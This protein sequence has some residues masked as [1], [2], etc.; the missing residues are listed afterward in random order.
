M[1]TFTEALPALQAQGYTNIMDA[2]AA[3]NQQQQQSY[4]QPIA[5][6]VL[7][8]TPPLVVPSPAAYQAPP[9]PSPA[10]A[11][12]PA[13]TPAATPAAASSSYLGKSIPQDV[14]ANLKSQAFTVVPAKYELLD[15]VTPQLVPA[16]YAPSSNV[17]SVNDS[18]VQYATLPNGTPV[19]L[20]YNPQGNL[21]DVRPSTGADIGGNL[22]ATWGPSGEWSPLQK[23][24]NSFLSAVLQVAPI[25]ISLV[26]PELIP[27]LGQSILGTATLGTAEAIAG[28]AAVSAATTAIA[29]GNI[30][31]IA[32]SAAKTAISVGIGGNVAQ[33]V[34][35]T[36]AQSGVPTNVAKVVASSVGATA[37]AISTGGD[38]ARAAASGLIGSVG[39]QT[40]DNIRT[41]EVTDLIQ[42]P[43]VQLAKADTGTMTD[44]SAP[45]T[46]AI[47]PISGEPI[48]SLEPVVVTAGSA[49]DK[50]F[51]DAIK[52]IRVLFSFGSGTPEQTQDAVYKAI[53]GFPGGVAGG[54]P[55]VD[56]G[57]RLFAW[58]NPDQKQ[59]AIRFMQIILEDPQ[60]SQENKI[61]AQQSI[62]RINSIPT[63]QEVPPSEQIPSVSQLAA[64]SE[65]KVTAGGPGGGGGGG[66]TPVTGTP[67]YGVSGTQSFIDRIKG[68]TAPS[69]LTSD[70]SKWTVP[71]GDGTR[72]TDIKTPG[73]G[74][75]SDVVGPVGPPVPGATTD[76]ISGAGGGYGGGY[77]TGAGPGRGPGV[78]PGEGPGESGTGGYTTGIT[79]GPG[80]PG[81]GEPTDVVQPDDKYPVEKVPLPPPPRV[82][83]LFT[84][85]L[86]DLA[87]LAPIERRKKT[88]FTEDE[89][90]PVGRWGSETLR[91]LLGI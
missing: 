80:G 25:V 38:P 7:T 4:F 33:E 6:P 10:P 23:T 30:E 11:P 16:H 2:L 19:V 48:Q 83:R 65:Q 78:G 76:R 90:E 47:S 57:F 72:I 36:L 8:P 41:A 58:D 69:V 64:P 59:Q 26:A 88:E 43:P 3:Y 24:S 20:T 45:T 85:Y 67:T 66:E 75:G 1:P 81:T 42:Q 50:S 15:G 82:T 44:V 12:A 27:T 32:T 31:Q 91:G 63:V 77:G 68:T 14:L 35:T 21:Q 70:V 37:G 18:F 9:A 87:G 54:D 62:Q 29:G 46:G 86:T 40:M 34:G 74:A 5:N 79:L 84:P 89:G 53:F 61:I 51:F 28:S 17:S 39:K 52:N 55:S 13:P 56:P 60:A 73:A 49:E 22:V 71:K